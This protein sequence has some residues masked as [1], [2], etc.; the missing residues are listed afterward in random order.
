MDVQFTAVLMWISNNFQQQIL[1]G[2]KKDNWWKQVSKQINE[3]NILGKNAVEMLFVQGRNLFM[4][5]AD[6][7]FGPRPKE[8]MNAELETASESKANEIKTKKNNDLIF[9]INRVTGAQRLYIPLKAAAKVIVIAHGDSHLGFNK[10][11]GTIAK[12]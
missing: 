5:E 11:Y 2:Y 7:Y 3:N 6:P 10:C 4:T 12:V 1:K 8:K 9:N